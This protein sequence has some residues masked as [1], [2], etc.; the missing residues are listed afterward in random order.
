MVAGFGIFSK[1]SFNVAL[2]LNTQ[3]RQSCNTV[4]LQAA[5]RALEMF[6]YGSTLA[7]SDSQYVYLGAT[8][9]LEMQGVGTFQ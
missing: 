5:I 7:C 3:L 8:S 1:S 6:G 9:A 4:E 2:P